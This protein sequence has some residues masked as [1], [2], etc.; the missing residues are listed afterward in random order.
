MFTGQKHLILSLLEESVVKSIIDSENVS[1]EA[2]T[3]AL[4]ECRVPSSPQME[5]TT[6]AINTTS[7]DNRGRVPFLVK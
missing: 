5:G 6:S 7:E 1:A 3:A 2:L 4:D